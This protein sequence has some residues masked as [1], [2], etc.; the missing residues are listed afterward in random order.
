MVTVNTNM[1]FEG[2]ELPNKSIGYDRRYIEPGEEAQLWIGSPAA[3]PVVGNVTIRGPNG[4]TVNLGRVELTSFGQKSERFNVP[5]SL[6]TGK[7]IV[8]GEVVDTFEIRNPPPGEPSTANS[9]QAEVPE[10]VTVTE[11]PEDPGAGLDPADY[12]MIVNADNESGIALAPSAVRDGITADPG[13]TEVDLSDGTTVTVYPRQDAD[14]TIRDTETG[15]PVDSPVGSGGVDGGLDDGGDRGVIGA[16]VAAVVLLV[17]GAAA[18][19][20]GGD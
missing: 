17:A 18:L 19:L 6:G 7:I 20:G 9:N 11:P 12:S 3:E 2:R 5:A 10:D 13:G 8:D 4:E 14:E 1:P 15:A 16:A